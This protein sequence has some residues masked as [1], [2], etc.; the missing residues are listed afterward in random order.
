MSISTI[1]GLTRNESART[2]DLNN[3]INPVLMY[4]IEFGRILIRS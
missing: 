4:R 2:K 3:K 1:I